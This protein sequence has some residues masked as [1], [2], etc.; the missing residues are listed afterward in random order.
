MG[1]TEETEECRLQRYAILSVLEPI[2]GQMRDA[3]QKALAEM[4][5]LPQEQG[6][7]RHARAEL[8]VVHEH[9]RAVLAPVEGAI[10]DIGAR[11]RTVDQFSQ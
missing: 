8:D 2:L 3:L 5:K 9:L 4:R 7:C 6:L 11:R 10:E 1:H